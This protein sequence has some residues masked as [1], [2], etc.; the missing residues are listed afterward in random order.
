MP[1]ALQ[2][3]DGHLN[4]CSLEKE[5]ALLAQGECHAKNLRAIQTNKN[6]QKQTQ[7]QN[8]P[9]HNQTKT[10]TTDALRW[11]VKSETTRPNPLLSAVLLIE[12][13]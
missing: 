10:N 3:S 11:Q 9:N 2:G 4:V 5:E 6:Q 8:K 13:E 7:P 1:C 12:I